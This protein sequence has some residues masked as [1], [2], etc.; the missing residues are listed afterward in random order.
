[1][2]YTEFFQL[3]NLP[4][5]KGASYRDFEQSLISKN[6]EMQRQNGKN[7]PNYKNVYNNRN[8]A[9]PFNIYTS[10][11]KFKPVIKKQMKN[12]N[13]EDEGQNLAF[14]NNYYGAKKIGEFFIEPD[15]IP[16]VP[17]AKT[18]NPLTLIK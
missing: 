7:P 12:L 17:I 14:L 2:N 13:L 5:F 11:Y 16:R 8:N 18:K 1:M 4:T 3:G 10:Q 15:E 6:D 9:M